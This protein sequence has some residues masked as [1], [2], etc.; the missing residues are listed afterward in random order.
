MKSLHFLT[1]SLLGLLILASGVS[2]HA[3]R[4]MVVYKDQNT[5][6][7]MHSR[8]VLSP[9][10]M[11]SRIYSVG[12]KAV[13]GIEIQESLGSVQSVIVNAENSAALSQIGEDV[14]IEREV[15]HKAPRP[16]IGYEPTKAWDF[17]ARYSTNSEI[18]RS[19][20]KKKENPALSQ[21]PASVEDF[22]SGPRTPWGILN[23]KAMEAWAGS[24]QGE[25]A[26]VM[27]LDT[28]ADVNHPAL[29]GQIEATK[30]FVNSGTDVE[31]KVGHGTHVAGTIAAALASDGF[32]G[33]AP[34]AKLLT[35]RVCSEEGCSNFAV[36]SG[37][38][39]AI[40]QK[41]DVVNLSLGS[42]FGSISEKNAVEKAE[43]AGITVVAASG[44][45]N[46]PSVG[47][48]AAYPTV[49]AVGAIDIKNVKADFS[50]WGP[51]L[52]IVGP[53]VDVISSVPAGTGCEPSVSII[54]AQS[55]N[56]P[57]T[58]FSGS[59]Y[60]T[61]PL[62][63]SLVFAGLGKAEDFKN[64]NMTGKFA[65]IER[66][67]I[68]FAEKVENALAA[69]AE[70]VVIFNNRPGL[71]SGAITEDGSVLAIPIVMI[72]QVKGNE[73]RKALEAGQTV[74]VAITTSP[75]SYSAYSGTSMASPHVAGVAA[76]VK[77]ANKGLTPAQVRDVLKQSTTLINDTVANQN[78]WYGSGAVNAENAVAKAIQLR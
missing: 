50:Q 4:F 59:A 11:A 22:V 6:S 51:E 57:A 75:S 62:K 76:L 26:R 13:P 30:D 60:L 27:V 48:P 20:K 72:E 46:K 64:L 44:N 7:K 3:E 35:G 43:K 70:G 40:E 71:M 53:G 65:L 29:K 74:E 16:I 68:T 31:D 63:K 58:C 52:D 23:V 61:T 2:A 45:D 14:V 25:G 12:N 34:K 19:K 77:A 37:L 28:G 78:N 55:Q 33:V 9:S 73:I 42:D 66:G 41:V 21:P 38:N 67:E 69:N 10:P 17:E 47:Y 8:W 32:T 39:W 56:V 49:L 18:Y 24:D 54:Q 1:G 5:F 36:V 15:F